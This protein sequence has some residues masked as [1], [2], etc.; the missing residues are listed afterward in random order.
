M[1]MTPII[2][3]LTQTPRH[4]TSQPLLPYD[5][6]ELHLNQ[7]R[8]I[9]CPEQ[10]VRRVEVVL[11]TCFLVGFAVSESELPGAGDVGVGAACAKGVLARAGAVLGGGATVAIL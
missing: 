5:L 8:R 10:L 4:D 11:S 6:V 1:D 3:V 9:P 2:A 7:V